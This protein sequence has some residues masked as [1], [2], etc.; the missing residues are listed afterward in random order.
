MELSPCLEAITGSQQPSAQC[1]AKLKEQVP[2]F[3]GYLNNPTLRPYID[4]P[5]AKKVAGF[6]GVGAPKC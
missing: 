2:C 3:C 6:V 1:C 5:N 4:S